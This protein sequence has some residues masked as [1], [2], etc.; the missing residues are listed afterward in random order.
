M[1]AVD[2]EF[3]EHQVTQEPLEVLEQMERKVKLDLQEI[4]EIP[5]QLAPMVRK[6]RLVLLVKLVERVFK[7]IQVLQELLVPLVGRDL[8]ET[9]GLLDHRVEWVL[10]EQSVKQ[11]P[12][13][14]L[15]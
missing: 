12:P 8:V 5:V 7:V 13:D 10:M 2:L 15:D 14:T 4:W 11:V 3:P 9:L 1:V 6:A